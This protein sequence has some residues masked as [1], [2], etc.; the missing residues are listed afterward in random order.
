MVL[1]E[2]Y[3]SARDARNCNRTRV[4]AKDVSDLFCRGVLLIALSSCWIYTSLSLDGGVR[5]CRIDGCLSH[6]KNLGVCIRHGKN[7]RVF[8]TM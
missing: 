2:G 1:K 3:A 4:F 6:A 8:I 5:L 7:L